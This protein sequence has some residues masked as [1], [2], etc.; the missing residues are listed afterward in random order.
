MVRWLTI[1]L[2]WTSHASGRPEIDVTDIA[3]AVQAGLMPP[4]SP[5]E[6]DAA[7]LG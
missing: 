2:I 4:L 6:R 7:D 3:Q 5:S 1:E